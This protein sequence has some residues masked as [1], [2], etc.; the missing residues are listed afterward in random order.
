MPV[1]YRPRASKA[2]RTGKPGGIR[3]LTD[4]LGDSTPFELYS[5]TSSNMP[6]SKVCS[7]EVFG[8]STDLSSFSD[9]I[10]D[11][12]L[13]KSD[14]HR[15]IVAMLRGKR[16][17]LQEG[18]AGTETT[19]RRPKVFLQDNLDVSQYHGQSSS[20]TDLM[21]KGLSSERDERGWPL[22]VSEGC[23]STQ[24]L[25]V[26]DSQAPSKHISVSVVD[27]SK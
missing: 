15:S 19:V 16:K 25:P 7:I 6:A 10:R 18:S 5:S 20:Y 2:N 14:L 26:G 9:S 12:H 1:S 8:N 3:S 17:K 27:V 23:Q 24:S 22:T 21:V 4:W 11:T 13:H